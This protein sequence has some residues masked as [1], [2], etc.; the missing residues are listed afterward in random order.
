[1]DTPQGRILAIDRSVSPP[2]ATV[3]VLTEVRCARCM[4]GK[5]CG[6]AL[7]GAGQRRRRFSVLLDD[8]AALGEGD[9]VAVELAPENVLHA[10]VLVYGWPLGGAVAGAAVAY[11]Y[12]AGDAGA[13]LSALAGI[14]A[15][16]ALARARLARSEC[17]RR[18]T[19]V[20]TA[21]L[22]DPR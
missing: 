19:P 12:G 21:R 14:A 13:A 3:E 1:M 5:G 18:F 11:L 4:A 7:L 6:A 20:V 8:R 2:R 9:R 15:G 16:V 10:A 22:G 17:L